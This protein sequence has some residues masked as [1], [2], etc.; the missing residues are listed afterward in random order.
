MNSVCTHCFCVL[1]YTTLVNYYKV[2]LKLSAFE[3]CQLK[4][5]LLKYKKCSPL[6]QEEWLVIT[7]EFFF[8]LC[9]HVKLYFKVIFYFPCLSGILCNRIQVLLYRSIQ[10]VGTSCCL[11]PVLLYH[12]HMCLRLRCV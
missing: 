10:K 2:K 1:L 11:W 9:F 4:L 6:I 5:E 7:V 8:C 3:N 12:A